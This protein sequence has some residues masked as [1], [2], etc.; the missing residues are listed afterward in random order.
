MSRRHVRTLAIPILAALGGAAAPAH[1]DTSPA[2]DPVSV[3]LGAYYPDTKVDFSV[4]DRAANVDSGTLN[5]DAGHA[6]LPRAR[7]DLL[8]F[9]TQGLS[10]DYY[11]FKRDRTETLADPLNIDG[12][13]ID[14]GAN[15]RGK[16]TL[17]IGN[18]SYRWWFG[19]DSDVF[20]VGVG[21]AYY[22]VKAGVS[23]QVDVNGQ[24]YSAA[25]G[26][27]DDAVAPLVTL[28]YRHAFSDALRVYLDASG[29][30][31]NNGKLNGHIYNAALGV[32]WFPWRNIGIGAE[33]AATR[34][35]LAA[36]H[37]GIDADLDLKLHGP[38]A[39]L[40]MRF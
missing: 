39:Y 23:A 9:G 17:D 13:V 37:S 11:R 18:A 15:I 16:F 32:E 38:A 36:T 21:A 29:V 2:L 22:R 14:P 19:G 3:W 6:T 7:V 25:Y 12:N 1:A 4:R 30:K 24:G 34:V 40:R 10:F 28:G 20:G 31:K 33:Y 26:Y 27:S 5:F 8:L 35:S